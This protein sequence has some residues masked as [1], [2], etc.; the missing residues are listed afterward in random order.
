MKVRI[1]ASN[2]NCHKKWVE[3]LLKKQDEDGYLIARK[4]G[5]LYHIGDYI[6]G[7]DWIEEEE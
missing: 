6:F 1:K 5:N 4:E 2:M 7:K 3:E